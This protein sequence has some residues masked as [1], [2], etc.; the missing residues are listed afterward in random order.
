MAPNP[1]TD[2]TRPDTSMD[3]RSLNDPPK[4]EDEA[5]NYDIILD[6]IGQLGKFQLNTSLWLFVPALLS[7][8][9]LM[10]HSFTGAIPPFR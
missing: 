8:L 6:H 2:K 3:V 10:S 1:N 4:V 7:G 9:V 5:F